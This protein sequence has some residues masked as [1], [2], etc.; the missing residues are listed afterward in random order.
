MIQLNEVGGKKK[1]ELGRCLAAIRFFFTCAGQSTAVFES[2]L[3]RRVRNSC[4]YSQAETRAVIERK[5]IQAPKLPTPLGFLFDLYVSFRDIVRDPA[6]VLARAYK[7]KQGDKK[8][9][10]GSAEFLQM[11]ATCLFFMLASG[12]RPSNVTRPEGKDASELRMLA[13]DVM[14]VGKVDGVL[15]RVRLV[16]DS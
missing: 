12:V 13:S 6:A 1:V 9:L 11:S 2:E 14:L 7:K 4:G 16:Y 8:I 5:T 3:V 10:T 15:G